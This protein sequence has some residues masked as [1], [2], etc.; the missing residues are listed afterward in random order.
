V[1]SE[2][3]EAPQTQGVWERVRF[4]DAFSEVFSAVLGPDAVYHI[5]LELQR[6][7]FSGSE[8]IIRST[9]EFDIVFSLARHVLEK[10]GGL[11]EAK[12]IWRAYAE[13]LKIYIKAIYMVKNGEKADYVASEIESAARLL[14]G[15]IESAI[16]ELAAKK[17]E[18]P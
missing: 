13:S 11:D 9:A 14:A 2:Q 5:Y 1:S 15:A 17:C 18:D 3:V 12:G 10:I 8:P 4:E 16:E 7:L 6:Y